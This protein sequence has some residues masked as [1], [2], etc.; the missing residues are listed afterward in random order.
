MLYRIWHQYNADILSQLDN[1][2]NY[3]SKSDEKN[4]YSIQQLHSANMWSQSPETSKLS[5]VVNLYCH[6]GLWICDLMVQI[7]VYYL[8]I[9]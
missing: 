7:N 5:L 9:W 6:C 2:W 1:D 8:F 3:L 4:Q